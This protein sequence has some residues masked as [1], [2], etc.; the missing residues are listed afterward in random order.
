MKSFSLLAAPDVL[1]ERLTGDIK[2][3]KREETVIQR[4]LERLAAY[5]ALDTVKIDTSEKTA[6]EVAEQE[7]F[8]S[9]QARS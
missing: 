2:D 8:G 1:K 4:S 5:R 3:G 6:E 9:L 7:N